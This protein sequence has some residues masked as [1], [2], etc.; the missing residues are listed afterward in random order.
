MKESKKVSFS[1]YLSH[2]IQ[3]FTPLLRELAGKSDL[4]VYYFS[5]VSV[6]GGLDKGFGVQ[7]KWDI[8][9]LE[10][11]ESEFIPNLSKR[12]ALDNNF[13]DLLNPSVWNYVRK[14]KSPIL[15]INGWS[16]FSVLLTIFAAK[17]FGKKV[18]LRAENTYSKEITKKPY[19]IFLKK[20]FLGS[21]LF[22][23]FIDKCLYIGDDSKAF[24]TFYKVP[25][26]KLIYTPYSVDNKHFSEQAA[27]WIPEKDSLK[28]EFS[29]PVERKVI[30]FTGKYM[31]VKRPL[32]LLKAFQLLGDLPVSLVMVGDG[33]LRGEMEAF[34]K[35]NSL[36]NIHLTGFVNQGQISKYYAI[37]DVFVLCSESETWGL[38]VNEAMNFSMPVVVSDTVGCA[39]DLVKEGVNGY[40]FS[41]GNPE[42]MAAKIR[43]LLEDE[44]KRKAAGVKAAEW[45]QN[46]NYKTAVENM[47]SAASNS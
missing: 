10:G 3:Y 39:R 11:Y 45:V 23:F 29:I 20:L 43:L 26:R 13:L 7:V 44:D 15:I 14:D 19:V 8:P 16:Y 5:D 35:S 24:F 4:K 32:D 40:T 30:L 1:Y 36:S 2:P 34:I 21:I 31:P 25:D 17:I 22:R 38:S 9:L 41:K 28:R 47:V 6:R 27:K 42:M 46:F 37:G 33:E 18:W 12:E